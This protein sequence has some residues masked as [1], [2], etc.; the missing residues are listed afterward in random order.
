MH[1]DLELS[2][3]LA[4]NI[5]FSGD[6]LRASEKSASR[7]S[8]SLKNIFYT[9]ELCISEE[10]TPELNKSLERV[11]SRMGIPGDSIEAFVYASPE[12]N[13]QCFAGDGSDCV[14]RF[15][16]A[17]VD[18]LNEAEFEFVV[19]HELGHFLLSHSKI[20]ADNHS[21]S[22]EFYM[23]QRAQE[24]SADRIGLIACDSLDSAVKALLKTVSGLNDKYLKF[25]VGAFLSQLRKTRGS[26]VNSHQST[27]PSILIRCRALL[28]FSLNESYINKSKTYPKDIMLSLDEK[29]KD[30]LDKYVDS[31]ARKKINEAKLDLS[32]WKAAFEIIQDGK[33]S[34]KE[35]ANFKKH[36]GEE[37]LAKLVGYLSDLSPSELKKAVEG[38]I[39]ESKLVLEHLIPS[40]FSDELELFEAWRRGT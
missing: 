30:D 39:E 3:K 5:R 31:S 37:T 8:S 15:S 36:F 23:Q 4:G 28:W 14:I 16:S 40:S 24:I 10:V 25:N 1:K 2:K 33:F 34:K 17:L 29:I 32:I 7:E 35:Q 22:I 19:G 12:I 13:A 26:I 18:I 20:N 6:S 11:L 21:E 38:K 27:H 9:N